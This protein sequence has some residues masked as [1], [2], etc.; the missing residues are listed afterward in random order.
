M[1]DAGAILIGSIFGSGTRTASGFR[2]DS[3]RAPEGGA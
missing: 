3:V 1:S 2:S